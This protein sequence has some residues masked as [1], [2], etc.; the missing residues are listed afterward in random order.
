MVRRER[1]R[2]RCAPAVAGD[3]DRLRVPEPSEQ[4]LEV[5]GDG[6]EVIAGIGT[7]ALP[8]PGEVHGDHPMRRHQA[9]GDEIPPARVAGQ[10]MERQQGGFAA[11]V[12]AHRQRET[13][14]STRYSAMSWLMAMGLSPL[15]ALEPSSGSMAVAGRPR[16]TCPGVRAFVGNRAVHAADARS[17]QPIIVANRA[18]LVLHA[19]DPY[20]GTPERLVK[21]AGGLVTAMTSLAPATDA[22]WIALARDSS[23]RTLAALGDPACLTTEDGTS[24]KVAF[25][26]PIASAYDLYYNVISNPLLWFIQHYLWDLAREPVVDETIHR[27]WV[28]G[29]VNVNQLVADR[30]LAE[31]ERSEKPVLV[32]V[33][34]Y[35][36]YSLPG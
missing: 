10:P 33:Q 26:E 27:A 29:Y 8:V 9:I 13:R 12:I 19:A 23:D 24:I 2:H 11:G 17:V 5:A 20:R 30:V 34:D 28:D 35:Q 25:V 1:Q 32:F 18:P 31:A 15:A 14:V 7:I 22:V 36:L 21:G 4:P 3:H 16:S 6:L